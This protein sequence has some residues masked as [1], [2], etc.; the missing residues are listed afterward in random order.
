MRGSVGPQIICVAPH[1]KWGI[2][3]KTFAAPRWLV[4]LVKSSPI[5][6]NKPEF[7]RFGSS[8]FD[9]CRRRCSIKR[10]SLFPFENLG[11][12][13]SM[14]SCNHL[15]DPGLVL[16]KNATFFDS[17]SSPL[18]STNKYQDSSVGLTGIPGCSRALY[19]W[20]TVFLLGTIMLSPDPA[21]LVANGTP[22]AG[23][24]PATLK[25]RRRSASPIDPVSSNPSRRQSPSSQAG[26]SSAA[27]VS[28]GY[29][30]DA[31]IALIGIRGTGLS[32][33]AVMA[34]SALGFR[35]LD[36]DQHF[37]QA[38]GLSRASYRSAHGN[39]EYRREELKLMQSMLFDNPTRTVI[40][41]GP[42]AVEGTGQVWLS[43]Y[44]KNH[45]VI[46]VMRDT[47]GI[48][49]HLRV[50]SV[51]TISRLAC[52][53]GPTYRSLSNFEFYNLSDNDVRE[54]DD[55]VDPGQQ[56]PKSLALKQMEHD[57]LQLIYSITRQA[58]R[59][60]EHE[61]RHSLSSLPP[62]S[63]P[64]TYALPLPIA[65]LDAVSSSLRGVDTTADAVELVVSLAQVRAKA[66]R[67]DTATANYISRRFYAAKRVVRL[68]VIFHVQLDCSPLPD[69]SVE[70]SDMVYYLDLVHHGLR[71]APEYLCVDISCDDESIRNL[72]AAKGATKIIGHDFS[73]CPTSTDWDTPARRDKIRRAE[74][75]G[76]D[77]VR[78]CQE[79]TSAAD[80]FAVQHFIHQIRTSGEH[81][82]PLIAYNTGRL[83]RMSCYLNSILTPVT[84]PAV[85]ST[86]PEHTSPHLLTVKEA[87]CALYSSLM[88]DQMY[89]GIYGANVAQSLSP[90]M[91]NAAFR[92]CGMPHEYR[93]FQRRTLNDLKQLASDP[94]FGGAS[95]TAPFKGKVVP[96]VDFM[97]P[98]ARAIGA[99]NTL[100]PLRSANLDSLLD[101]NRVGRVAALFGDNTDWIGIHTCV[102]RNLSP[103]NAIK[104]RTTGLVLGAGGMA[105]AA[106]YAL[107][108]LGVRTIFI[109]NRTLHRAEEL[110]TQFQ[111]YP[112]P[113]GS[114]G[115]R[116]SRNQDGTLDRATNR[117][118]IR[119]IPS[120][121]D[122]WPEDADYPTIIVSCVATSDT[123]HES[124]ADTSLHPN[125][126]ASPTGGVV[127][128]LSYTPLETPLLKQI[129]EMSDHGWIAVD[130]LEVLPE[131]GMVQFELFTS[132]KA[133]REL[134][135]KE[136]LQAYRE[137]RSSAPLDP[138]SRRENGDSNDESAHDNSPNLTS[139]G[140]E[141]TTKT[142][143][144]AQVSEQSHVYDRNFFIFGHD[145][146]HSLSPTLHNAGFRELGLPY[147]YSIHQSETVDDTV[148]ELIGRP[149]FGGASVTY[150]HKLQV[151]RLLSSVTPRA[152]KIG[153][154][155]TIVVHQSGKGRTLTGDNT[156]WLGIKRCIERSGLDNLQSSSALVLGAG[157]A[158]RAACY[159]IQT[160][161]IP[162][163]VIVNRTFSRAEEM[164]SQ[165]KEVQTQAFGSLEEASQAEG[166][167][168]R[169]VVACVPADDLG[170][171]K[172][173]RQLFSGSDAGV[174][175]EM[176][177]RPKT[178]GMMVVAARQPGWKV[179]RGTDV[180]EEQAY[181]QFELWTGKAAPVKVMREAMQT[182]PKSNM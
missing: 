65:A 73:D 10:S 125:W 27:V 21:Q 39:A 174:L 40:A 140:Q 83:G 168:V 25:R 68:P 35:L 180:L 99:V 155:N 77:I 136:V 53:S 153:A 6:L 157:G 132:R 171:D 52:L 112:F 50:W 19:S 154:V 54:H 85:R 31:S 152:D 97:S 109:H 146:A 95:I 149:D 23:S 9:I 121:D 57:F 111:G 13:C 4:R 127:V 143:P 164:A 166:L 72:V 36:A 22:K 162:S 84:H 79:A 103:I 147:H 48:R 150:P 160:L 134:M 107:I 108:R 90:A 32:T 71:L 105:R 15:T 101:K 172:I 106:T 158:A 161:G 148:E 137:R 87:Q 110:V 86:A 122:G 181:A 61:A 131:Q 141:P 11:P 104:R 130:G 3:A 175:V 34:S 18:R 113:T 46:Y 182:R 1:H 64:F 82:I 167:P 118:T 7:P 69:A 100:L 70:D 20:K 78:L 91:H 5:G 42:G 30:P 138:T 165:F 58:G 102:R 80:N 63:R 159:A 55:A 126:L 129:R 14:S 16:T 119:I 56:S 81:K 29:A 170:E 49:Q 88:L 66:S 75:L 38:K 144:A 60:A 74:N 43:E 51:E 117:P 33:L 45:P 67:F 28:R 128:E 176:A 24:C 12:K 93:I 62:E 179:F 17:L 44:A 156:D 151:G 173:P 120:K 2:P 47:E 115:P 135:R 145:I 178:T 59:H 41:C 94:S 139:S 76:C 114:D 169:V 177:Y 37:Y 98:D 116:L 96:L 123:N 26:R 163:L 92:Y 142:R 124:S 133:P 89:F 8:T